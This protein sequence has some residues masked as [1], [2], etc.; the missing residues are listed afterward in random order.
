M[1]E[2]RLRGPDWEAGRGGD[3]GPLCGIA[4]PD[5]LIGHFGIRRVLCYALD[6]DACHVDTSMQ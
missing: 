4:R 1:S 3:D 5:Y 2:L 6:V